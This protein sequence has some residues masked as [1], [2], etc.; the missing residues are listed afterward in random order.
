MRLHLAMLLSREG[1]DRRGSSRQLGGGRSAS[2]RSQAQRS[3]GIGEKGV[4]LKDPVCGMRMRPE[5]AVYVSGVPRRS[6]SLL[7]GGV[8]GEVRPGPLHDFF[9]VYRTTRPEGEGRK[10]DNGG[11]EVFCI[12]V[13]ATPHARS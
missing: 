6:L 9:R 2:R 8:Q 7:L 10:E 11:P 13:N 4:L 3:S 5:E 1:Y 12:H